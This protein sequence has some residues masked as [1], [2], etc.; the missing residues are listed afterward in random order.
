MAKDGTGTITPTAGAH[1]VDG[2]VAQ[3]IT[4]SATNFVNWTATGGAVLAN[5]NS[6]ATTVTL[7][8]NSTV[9]AHWSA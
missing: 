9:T 6:P 2:G 8:A 3:A 4:A 1:T 7:T 5:A